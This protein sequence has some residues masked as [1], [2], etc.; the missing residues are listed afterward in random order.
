MVD[1]GSGSVIGRDPDED[2]ILQRG[3]LYRFRVRQR[4]EPEP[5]PKAVEIVRRIEEAQFREFFEKRKRSS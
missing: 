3:V 2:R 1:A 4:S 5:D